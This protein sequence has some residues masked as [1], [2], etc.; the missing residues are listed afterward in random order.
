[1]DALGLIFAYEGDDKMGELSATRTTSSIPFGGRYRLIDFMLSNLSNAGIHDVGVIMQEGYQSL[2]DHIGSGRD[3]DL[4][5]KLGGIALLPPFGYTQSGAS[6]KRYA[7]KFRGKLDA[8]LSILDFIKNSESEYVVLANGNCVL[9]IDMNLVFDAHTKSGAD[10]TVVCAKKHVGEPNQ[11]VYYTFGKDGNATSIAAYPDVAGDNESLNIYLMK[12]DLLEYLINYGKVRD[13]C[14]FEREVLRSVLGELKIMPY[15]FDGY[16]AK[17]ESQEGYYKHSMELLNKDVRNSLF[18][19]NNLI[20]ARIRDEAPTYYSDSAHVEGS[21][22][23]DGCII[24][25][26]VENSILFRGVHVKTGATVKNSIVMRNCIIGENV[27]INYVIA[28]KNVVF[29]QNGMIMG[30]CSYPSVIRKNS[31]V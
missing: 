1:M 9:N 5:R 22:I 14:Y 17:M 16:A 10:I 6:E 11:S 12:K 3:W 28:D 7:S 23:A 4:A 24:E 18:N 20:Y 2:L 19:K 15:F 31:V 26:R 21:L 30:S 29:K 27:F 25:G 8:L 13:M